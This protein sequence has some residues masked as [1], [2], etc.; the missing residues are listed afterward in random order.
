MAEP[1]IDIVGTSP[2]LRRALAD[3]RLVART[4]A[5]VVL[6][7]ES[8][9]GKELFASYLHRESGRRGPFVPVNC[10]ALPE[11]IVE[12]LL[13]GHRRGAFSGAVE[14]SAGLVAAA[15]GGTLFLDEI[16]ELPLLVQAKLLRVLQQG[17]VLAV[18]E[19]RERR[20][21]V[22]IVAASHRDLR[23]RVAAGAFREDLYFR[24]AKFEVAVPA[25]RERG[26]DVVAIARAYLTDG[27]DLAGRRR[28][29][30]RNAEPVLVRYP[31]PGNVRELQNVLFRAALRARGGTVTPEDL[32]AELP[33]AGAADPVPAT[34]RVLDLIASSGEVTA[35]E[36]AASCGLSRPTAK[37]LLKALVE[38]GDL[39]TVGQGKATRYRRRDPSE[40][41]LDDRQR[42]AMELARRE[43]RISRQ[44]F[45]T[46][47]S[48]PLRSAG[49]VLADLVAVGLL[50]PDGRKGNGS[51]YV[52]SD[53]D[54]V[55][56]V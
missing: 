11:A 48:I 32:V 43:G 12:S 45:A 8:G 56:L 22:R 46:E 18:G 30:A 28:A 49:R 42:A 38:A 24:L 25:L 34:A 51:G 4:P 2:A 55:P 20:V 1:R 47:A 40:V 5:P 35:C 44:G 23:E 50:A 17:T 19:A 54:R 10:A 53:P 52:L 13:F 16:A 33:G 27:P 14:A 3:V 41:V 6:R 26:R 15:D 7:G 39:A 21:D 36:V 31:W 37:R 29:L 9:T